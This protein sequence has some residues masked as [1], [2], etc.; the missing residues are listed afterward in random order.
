M[1]TAPVVQ[2]LDQVMADLNPS[3]AGQQA[4]VTQERSGLGAKYDAQRAGITAEKGQGFNTINNQATGRGGS[5]SGIPIDEQATYLATKYLPGMQAADAQQNEDDLGLQKEAAALSTDQ[6][7]Q[8]LGRIDK[9]TS[10]LNSWNLQQMQQE[11]QARENE[12]NRRATASNAAADRAAAAAAKSGPTQAQYLIDAFTKAAADPNWKKN[13]YTENNVIG[14][15]AASYGLNYA[16]A[17]KQVYS[18][19]KQYYT[20]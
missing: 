18:F 19:R 15:Y 9:Q 5:F 12:L 11:A 16:D 10:D 7:T 1:A 17:A 14:N 13:G 20:F 2:T 4:L 8:A 3:Y 6:R